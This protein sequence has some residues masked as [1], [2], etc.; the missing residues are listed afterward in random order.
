MYSQKSGARVSG[1]DGDWGRVEYH[2]EYD[3]CG[4]NVPGRFRDLY[5]W[6]ILSTGFGIDSGTDL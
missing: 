6:S 2:R 1:A 3:S 4:E 5:S